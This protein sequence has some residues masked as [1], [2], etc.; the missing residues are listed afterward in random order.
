MIQK[1][2]SQPARLWIPKIAFLSYLPVLTPPD[3]FEGR[4]RDLSA[5]L[6]E[7]I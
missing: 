4:S 6:Y 3:D 2:V 5:A 1:K 7:V